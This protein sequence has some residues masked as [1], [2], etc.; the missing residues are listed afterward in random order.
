MLALRKWHA[1]GC[2]PRGMRIFLALA[3]VLDD[4]R[5]LHSFGDLLGQ[6]LWSGHDYLYA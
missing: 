2:E 5:A 1:R 4:M 6:N 3:F